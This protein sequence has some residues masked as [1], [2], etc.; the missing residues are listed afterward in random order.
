MFLDTVKKVIG[1]KVVVDTAIVAVKTL[2]I[3][4]V[5]IGTSA[6]AGKKIIK[7]QMKMVEGM[8]NKPEVL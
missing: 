7:D 4:G 5:V 8:F 1:N 6:V 2:V 3:C